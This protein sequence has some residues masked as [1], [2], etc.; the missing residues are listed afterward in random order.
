MQFSIR[1]LF[2]LTAVVALVTLV[3]IKVPMLA[4]AMLLWYL[5]LVLF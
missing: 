1:A 4:L 3:L 2:A 5:N